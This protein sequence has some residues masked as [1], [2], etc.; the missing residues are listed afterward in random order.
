MEIDDSSSQKRKRSKGSLPPRK[1]KPQEKRNVIPKGFYA[2][3]TTVKCSL[4]R[5]ARTKKFRHL[6]KD[7]VTMFSQLKYLASFVIKHHLYSMLERNKKIDQKLDQ[8]YLDTIFRLLRSEDET[9]D[10]V[11]LQASVQ[12]IRDAMPVDIWEVEISKTCYSQIANLSAIEMLTNLK[13]HIQE[14]LQTSFQHWTKNQIRAVMTSEDFEDQRNTMKTYFDT[15]PTLAFYPRYL[16]WKTKIDKATAKMKPKDDDDVEFEEKMARKNSIPYT[17]YLQMMYEMRKECQELEKVCD[18]PMKGISVI[19]QNSAKLHFVRFDTTV[20]TLLYK[21]LFGVKTAM[22]KLRKASNQD[23]IWN[24]LF[25]LKAI[26]FLRK[27]LNFG[28]SI[29]TNGVAVCIIFERNVK[30]KPKEKKETSPLPY[31]KQTLTRLRNGF[32]SETKLLETYNDYSNDIATSGGTSVVDDIRWIGVDPGVRSIMTTWTVGENQSSFGLSQGVYRHYSGLN[33]QKLKNWYHQHLWFVQEALNDAPSLT[34]V[35]LKDMEA[36][37]FV[38]YNCWDSI[39]G[40]RSK[41]RLLRLEYRRWIQRQQFCDR[42]VQKAYDVATDKGK[43]KAALIFGNGA[44]RGGFMKVKGGGVKG[45]VLKLKRLLAKKLPVICADAFRTTK[46]CLHCGQE[47]KHPPRKRPQKGE[48]YGVSYCTETDHHRMVNR[49]VDAAQKIGYR[50]L[51][52]LKGRDIGPWARECKPQ[53]G[54]RYRHLEE[55]AHSNYPSDVRK[56]TG[57]LR[58]HASA[59]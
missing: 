15:L 14:H 53:P 13:V 36:Y 7:I 35:S 22:V 11:H 19:P 43:R 28:W 52:Q 1:R 51:A 21:Q 3:K 16:F 34:S 32:H 50:F 48:I 6:I 54:V 39:W 29:T 44:D 59:E 31:P 49:D 37:L 17:D 45:P 55:F 8:S 9:C 38:V 20:I 18:R 26:R 42:F 25:K 2:K 56:D 40:Y 30:T 41:T 27:S 5:V 57:S 10:D 33:H 46:L 58:I 4:G 24:S 23:R 12:Y 47:L